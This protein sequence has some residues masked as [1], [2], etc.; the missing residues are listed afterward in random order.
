[1]GLRHRKCFLYFPSQGFL[2]RLRPRLKHTKKYQQQ[3]LISV[4]AT[5][6][7]PIGLFLDGTKERA[8]ACPGFLREPQRSDEPTKKTCS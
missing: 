7:F 6:S 8:D 4:H 1:M 5:I 2:L 3:T